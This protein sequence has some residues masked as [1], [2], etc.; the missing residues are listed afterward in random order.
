MVSSSILC[1]RQVSLIKIFFLKWTITLSSL[2][3]SLLLSRT[4]L[5]PR[6]TL[7]NFF[8]VRFPAITVGSK[9]PHCFVEAVVAK[10]ICMIGVPNALLFLF[11]ASCLSREHVTVDSHA[12]HCCAEFVPVLDCVLVRARS[13]FK[14]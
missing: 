12:L 7:S 3:V 13:S 2:L 6:L 10:V 14:N 4:F 11:I 8:F 1:L 5:C 9:L